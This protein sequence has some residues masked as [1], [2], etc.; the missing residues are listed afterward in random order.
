LRT[1]NDVTTLAA[2]RRIYLNQISEVALVDK[3]DKLVTTLSASGLRG[4]TSE[5]V[6]RLKY[7]ILGVWITN[8]D[9]RAIGVV[10][11]TDL[12]CVFIPGGI[13]IVERR[14]GG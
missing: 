1:T 10:S 3:W 6:D 13:R 4:L 5:N 14:L 2:F 8:E 7:P 11:T 12:L 9:D